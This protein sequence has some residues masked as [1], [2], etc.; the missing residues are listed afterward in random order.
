MRAVDYIK[1]PIAYLVN[2]D[3]KSDTINYCYGLIWVYSLSLDILVGIY[4]EKWNSLGKLLTDC[5]IGW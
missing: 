5:C 3:N 2:I 4:V 1:R